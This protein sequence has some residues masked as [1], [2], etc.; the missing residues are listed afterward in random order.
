MLQIA[1]I[2]IE[3]MIPRAE[4]LAVF[5]RMLSRNALGSPITQLTSHFRVPREGTEMHIVL[6]DN[7]PLST[8]TMCISVPSRGTRKWEVSC[9]I[10]EPSALRDNIRLN[11]ARCSA[12]GIIFSM[13]IEAICSIANHDRFLIASNL[14]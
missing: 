4:H 12:R 11:T 8:S 9:V 2:G 3:K 14:Q 5:S 7:G 1:S 6:V 10:G 13:P